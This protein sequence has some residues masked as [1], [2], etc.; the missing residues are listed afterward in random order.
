MFC[1]LCIKLR[2]DR[3]G[4]MGGTVSELATVEGVVNVHMSEYK[5]FLL[6]L[7]LTIESELKLIL[8]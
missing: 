2:G 7:A 4:L 5:R 6:L 1:D 8:E 3:N